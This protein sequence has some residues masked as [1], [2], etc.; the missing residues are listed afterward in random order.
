[1]AVSVAAPR[2]ATSAGVRAGFGLFTALCLAT[3]GAS[4]PVAFQTLQRPC[5]V[6]G[7]EPRLDVVGLRSLDA[8]GLDVRWYAAAFLLLYLVFAGGCL[9]LGIQLVRRR[10]ADPMA[11]LVAVMLV[12]FG[13]TFPYTINQLIVARP[14]WRIPGGLV[15]MTS[16]VA[17]V[18]FAYWFP[19]RRPRP[20]WTLLPVSVWCLVMVPTQLAPNSRLA[21]SNLPGPLQ[22]VLVVGCL[23]P[24]P[25]VQLRRLRRMADPVQRQQAKWVAWGLAVGVGGLVTLSALWTSGGL[26]AAQRHSPLLAGL[27]QLSVYA[28]ITALPLSVAVAVARHRL[29]E[30]D[31]LIRRSLVYAG[32]AAALALAYVAVVLLGSRMVPR[33]GSRGLAV[34]GT[35]VVALIVVPVRDWLAVAVRRRFYGDREEPAVALRRLSNR[36]AE[37]STPATLVQRLADEVAGILRLPRVEVWLGDQLAAASGQPVSRPSTIVP[38]SYDGVQLGVLR[39]VP[40]PGEDQLQ[41]PDQRLLEEVVDRAGAVLQA[42]RVSR[43]LRSTL[44]D[45]AESR[46]RLVAA[47]EEE[48]AR[49]QRDL[50]DELGPTLAGIQLRLEATLD[51]LD[52]DSGWLAAELDTLHRLVHQCGSEVRSIVHGLRPVAL[53]ELSLAEA[54]EEHCRETALARGITITLQADQA[55]VQPEIEDAIFRIL[56]E[57]LLNA[58]RHGHARHVAVRLALETGQL[59][60][61]VTDDGHGLGGTAQPGTG[62]AGMRARA[63]GLGGTFTLTPGPAGGAQVR[64]LLPLTGAHR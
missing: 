6:T 30:V 18:A 28:V 38:I 21:L 63:R 54:L 47:Q 7:C 11:L 53:R 26:P 31:T 25:V 39:V 4:L 48:R 60:L 45:L 36:L 17:F 13:T 64:A 5:H 1:M 61:T 59:V 34:A 52:T 57:A 42:E 35:V 62:V 19:E 29:F 46:G 51:R 24:I 41:A 9:V 27:A 37:A 15:E 2:A 58:H 23:V 50:H 55:V 44:D 33:L 8:S 10:P 3:F 22:G 14:V 40:R 12:A 43:E 56:Q 32:T 49:I 16:Q 20:G